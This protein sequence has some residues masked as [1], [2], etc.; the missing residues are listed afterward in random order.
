MPQPT[1]ADLR[2]FEALAPARITP[3][4]VRSAGISEQAAAWDQKIERRILIPIRRVAISDTTRFVSDRR[5]GWDRR[6]QQ[7]S[8]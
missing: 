8:L 5:S 4:S 3:A 6:K 2:Q 7:T 1:L